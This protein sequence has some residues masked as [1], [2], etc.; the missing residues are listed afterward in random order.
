MLNYFK[1]QKKTRLQY[2]VS[3]YLKRKNYEKYTKKNN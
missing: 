3:S 1:K 2:K